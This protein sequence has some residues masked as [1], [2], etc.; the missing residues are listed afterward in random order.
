[1]PVKKH[2]FRNRKTKHGALTA[3]LTVLVIAVAVLCNVVLD[4]LTERYGWYPSLRGPDTYALSDRCFSLVGEAMER[5]ENPT[6]RLIFC[7]TEENLLADGSSKMVYSTA[8]ELSERFGNI[9][10]SCYDIW[11]NPTTVR[12]YT[13]TLNP[14]TGETETVTLS[15]SSVIVVS[16]EYHRA[17]SLTEFFSFE[18]ENPET[19]WAYDGEKTLASAILRAV[20]RK[21]HIA[22][23]L[24]NH[25][26]KFYDYELL[27]L[28]DDA[29]YTIVY[30]DLYKDP[31]PADCELIVSY[32][33]TSDLVDDALSETSETKILDA[34][35]AGKGKSF[36]VFFG[37]ATPS[38]PNFESYL[39]AWGIASDYAKDTAGN[40][41]R[42][43]IQDP[44][45]SLTSD[46]YTVYGTAASSGA[47]GELLS[48]LTRQTVFKNATSFH[49]ASSGYEDSGDGTYR[50]FDGKRTVYPLWRSGNEALCWANGSVV[51][52]GNAILFA[53]T[54]QKNASGSSFVGA[55]GSVDFSAEN[56]LQSAVYGNADALLRVLH[57]MGKEQ[58]PEGL[59]LKPFEA[60]RISLITTSQM[61]RWTV[62][63]AA[64]PAVVVTV[65]AVV[66]LV[67]RRR[68]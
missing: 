48:G 31:I 54:E 45:Q 46:G 62:L 20:D 14:L 44:T 53:L 38:L 18:Q 11:L 40:E 51:G 32:N 58:T 33:P 6:V 55:V 49:I 50:S 22:C 43:M 21:Q 36:L 47:S 2:L 37:D 25:G 24:N 23:V 19:A 16:G 26:E 35:L 7:N 64:V 56:L 1:M 57:R 60:T 65:T 9:S 28:L 59:T 27:Y 52:G 42:Y 3:L 15:K 30:M 4:T 13:T 63:L 66:V 67:R 39:S 10:V 34:F 29:G 61:V 8:K 17:Y 68:F 12:D 41:F 5:A